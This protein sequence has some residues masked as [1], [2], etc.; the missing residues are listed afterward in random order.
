VDH[1]EPEATIGAML[2]VIEYLDDATRDL[3][4]GCSLRKFDIG[5]DCGDEPFAFQT[6]LTH[7]ALVR[8]TGVGAGLRITLYSANSMG[9][10]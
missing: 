3:W 7:S 8:V 2:D 10:D 1:S 4:V 9:Q 6:A 5:Y